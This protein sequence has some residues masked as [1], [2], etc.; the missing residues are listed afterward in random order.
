MELTRGFHGRNFATAVEISKFR[1]RYP[2][3]T[4]SLRILKSGSL[5]RDSGILPYPEGWC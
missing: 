1:L 5:V 3:V 4:P 2:F